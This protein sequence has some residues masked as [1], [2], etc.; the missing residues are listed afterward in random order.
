MTPTNA[1]AIFTIGSIWIIVICI[2]EQINYTRRREL[3]VGKLIAVNFTPAS[4]FAAEI[5][6]ANQF[7]TRFWLAAGARFLH[8]VAF[9]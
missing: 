5:I 1:L 6:A 8:C 2:L 4:Y 9:F 7:G 3:K